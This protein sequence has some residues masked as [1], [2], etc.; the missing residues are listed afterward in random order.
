MAV[1]YLASGI[2]NTQTGDAAGT[3]LNGTV[4]TG[5]AGAGNR[6]LDVCFMM[7]GRAQS[8]DSVTYNSVAMTSLG[9]LVNQGPDNVVGQVFRLVAPAT[10]S[11]TLTMDPSTAN[12][13]YGIEMG[14]WVG[15]GVD[16]ATPDSYMTPVQG[17][18]SLGS[19]AVGMTVTG[20]TGDRALVFCGIRNTTA[21]YTATPT[22]YTEQWDQNVGASLCL[23]FGDADGAASV[24]TTTTWTDGATATNYIAF[25]INVAQSVSTYTPPFQSNITVSFRAA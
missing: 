14:W 24:A 18:N 10:G 19:T 13:T 12:S 21:G 11:N 23:A 16:Q 20:A 5:A 6:V 2:D 8:V 25:G 22:N 4:D 15:D 1:G 9:A 17:G 3:A 7:R